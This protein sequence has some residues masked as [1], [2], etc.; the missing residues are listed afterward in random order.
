MMTHET[1]FKWEFFCSGLVYLGGG[2][3]Q[4]NI[5]D[6]FILNVNKIDA[7]SRIVLVLARQQISLRNL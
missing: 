1:T 6:T 4:P 3:A 5:D 7:F 2:D